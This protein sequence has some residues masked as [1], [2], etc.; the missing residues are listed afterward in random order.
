MPEFQPGFRISVI[1]GIVLI[2]GAV[3][4][5]FTYLVVPL[6]AF[7][8]GYVVVHFFLFC[9]LFRVA[10]SLELIWSGL[11]VALC[12]ASI[13]LNQ[14]PWPITVVLSLATT[15]VVIA[16]TLRKP[17]YHGALWKMINP[18]LPEWWARQHRNLKSQ[19]ESASGL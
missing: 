2:A 18:D 14:P 17:S 11:F 6:I 4:V 13:L 1:D 10:R 9:N 5:V 19:E 3:V 8:V 7:I 16:L 12:A 15:C